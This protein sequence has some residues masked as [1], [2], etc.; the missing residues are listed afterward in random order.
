VTG[1]RPPAALLIVALASSALAGVGPAS[2]ALLGDSAASTGTAAT[3]TLDPPTALAASAVGPTVTLTWTAS[4]DAAVADGYLVLRASASGGPFTQVGTADPGTATATTDVVP[5]SGTWYY[6]L[7]TYAGG[8]PWTSPAT[9]EASVVASV[10][11]STSW[12][13]CTL[14]GAVTSGSGDND[15]YQAAPAEACDDD[16]VFAVDTDTG[17]NAASVCSNSG[18]DRHRFWGFS[19]GLPSVVTSIDGIEVRAD[20]HA[21]SASNHPT[22]CFRLS[23]DGGT[24]WTAYKP[25]GTELTTSETTYTVGGTADAW[26]R[27]SWSLADLDSSTFRLEITDVAQ[28][29]ARDLYLDGLMV[30]VHYTP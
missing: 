25:L 26:G 23:W 2:T 13:A 20:L 30:R 11:T 24:S 10:T 28:N 9:S 18:K 19:F 7:M 12:T 22:A 6:A 27:A 8:A 29:T 3:E 4:T 5:S 1:I 16:S 15:G 21:D 14:A 17:T